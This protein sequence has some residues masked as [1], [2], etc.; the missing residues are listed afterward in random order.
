MFIC[1]DTK[2]P[3]RKTKIAG[4]IACKIKS[5]ILIATFIVFILEFVNDGF[6]PVTWFRSFLYFSG[7]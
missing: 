6:F 1:V 7:K 4:D 2:S 5:A 3:K